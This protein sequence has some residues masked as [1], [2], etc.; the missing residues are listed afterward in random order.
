[1]NWVLMLL[2]FPY[3]SA[4]EFLNGAGCPVS[5]PMVNIL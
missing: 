5:K 1:M 2:V 3:V 4:Y